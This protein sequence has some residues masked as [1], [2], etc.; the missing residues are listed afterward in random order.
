MKSTDVESLL[1]LAA[2]AEQ[3]RPAIKHLKGVLLSYGEDL[4]DVIG[5]MADYSADTAARVY[6]RLRDDHGLNDEVALSLAITI[7]SNIKQSLLGG[8]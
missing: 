2:Q 4:A 6:K 7:T 8:K 3:M 5:P 1:Q